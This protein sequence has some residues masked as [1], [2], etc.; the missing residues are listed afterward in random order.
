MTRKGLVLLLFWMDFFI[1]HSMLWIVGLYAPVW[2]ARYDFVIL[3]AALS[4]V[5]FWTIAGIIWINIEPEF[6]SALAGGD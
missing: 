1:I 3:G 5:L 6:I 4:G 2:S